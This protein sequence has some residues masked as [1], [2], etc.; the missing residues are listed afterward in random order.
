MID[1]ETQRPK[2]IPEYFHDAFASNIASTEP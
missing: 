2:K 1:L